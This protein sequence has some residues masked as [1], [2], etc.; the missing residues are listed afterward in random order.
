MIRL[1]IFF[2]RVK[3]FTNIGLEDTMSRILIAL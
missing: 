1:A 3:I 2:I